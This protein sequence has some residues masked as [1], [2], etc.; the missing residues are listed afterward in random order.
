MLALIAVLPIKCVAA[1]NSVITVLPGGTFALHF[2]SLSAVGQGNL[3]K[4]GSTTECLAINGCELSDEDGASQEKRK[5]FKYRSHG[6]VRVRGSQAFRAGK[7]R[8]KGPENANF[9]DRELISVP[10]KCA[11]PGAVRFWRNYFGILQ[12]FLF[13]AFHS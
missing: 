1:A 9:S 2:A 3:V 7:D 13:L 11:C 5:G 4:N 6:I 12:R 8:R 10:R